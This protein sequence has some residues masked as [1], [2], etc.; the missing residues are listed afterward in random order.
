MVETVDHERC[1]MDE[2][3]LLLRKVAVGDVLGPPFCP[4]ASNLDGL[5]GSRWLSAI[6][7]TDSSARQQMVVL[8][9]SMMPVRWMQAGVDLVGS[10]RLWDGINHEI[11]L[12]VDAVLSSNCHEALLMVRRR[13]QCFDHTEDQQHGNA[14]EE[15]DH[16]FKM[17]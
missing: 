10:V 5:S 15:T 14:D 13:R 12:T 17:R 2:G 6:G 8:R 3:Q 7:N 9:P 11:V 1:S 16:V 4:A